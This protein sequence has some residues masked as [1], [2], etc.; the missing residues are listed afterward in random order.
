[1]GFVR[2]NAG[3]DSV[4]LDL[5]PSGDICLGGGGGCHDVLVG[6]YGVYPGLG[7]RT[8]AMHMLWSSH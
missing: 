7:V 3:G 6:N 8:C 4:A 1:M 5:F 2:H